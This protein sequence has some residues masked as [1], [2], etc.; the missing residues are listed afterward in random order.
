MKYINPIRSISAFAFILTFALFAIGQNPTP[1]PR[2]S[3]DT[4]VIKVDSRLVIVPVSVVDAN[5]EPVL[6]LKAEDFKVTEENR[7]QVLENVGDALSTPLEIALLFDV[8]ASTD[9]MFKFQQE[10]AA[11]FLKEVMRPIDRATIFTVGMKP[12]LVQARNTADSS[13]ISVRSIQPTKEQTAFYDSVSFATRYLRENAP[14]ASRKVIVVISDG[15]DTN[16]DGVLKAIW[17]AERKISD[18]VQGAELRS[19]R[20]KARDTAKVQEQVKVLKTL[21]N[22]DTVFYSIN[23]GGS[24]YK[25]NQM[26]EFGQENLR[27]FASETGGTAFLPKFLPIDTKD[28][29]ANNNNARQ[30][31]A[32]LERIFKQLAN[33][34]RAQ[35]LIQ[36]YSTGEYADGRFVKVNVQLANPAG[37]TLRSREGYF[38]RN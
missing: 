7:P 15:E 5:G 37:K 35:Y 21:Q 8:S 28:Y 27:R 24:S 16:S 20:V 12:V 30:N 1:T 29:L 22:A 34:L 14:E 26:S 3:E 2:I 19:L 33:E 9:A 23:P 11:K 38:V 13:M 10:T 18:N 36:Y 4:S 17:A 32:L 6:G 25:L 31:T